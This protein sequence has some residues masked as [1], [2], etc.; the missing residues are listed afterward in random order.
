[1]RDLMVANLPQGQPLSTGDVAR[2]LMMTPEGVRYLVRDGQIA[3]A[4]T[5]AGW[6]TFRPDDLLR[7]AERRTKARA[8]GTLPRR[9]K[10]GPRGQPRQ[11]AF[12]SLFR[13]PLQ[14]VR[15][16]G[17]TLEK[18][19]VRRADLLQKG[20]VSD[21]RPDGNRRAAGGRR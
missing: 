12:N 2:G 20:R 16:S 3:C 1:M 9:R 17:P 21:N 11:L 10:L 14:L 5:P 13:A 19:Q 8:I 6:R 4:V 7:L 15:P 18:S